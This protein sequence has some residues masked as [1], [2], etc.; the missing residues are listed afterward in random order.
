MFNQAATFNQ[1]PVR[2]GGRGLRLE[3]SSHGCY[4]LSEPRPIKHP[5]IQ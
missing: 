5:A 2:L 3:R 1:N 4:S